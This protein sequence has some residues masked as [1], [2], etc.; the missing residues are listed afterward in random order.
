MVAKICSWCCFYNSQVFLC[1]KQQINKH[2]SSDVL[3]KES[4]NSEDPTDINKT[5]NHLWPQIIEYIKRS[6]HMVWFFSDLIN[7]CISCTKNE[8]LE[9]KISAVKLL[10]NSIKKNWQSKHLRIF[11][12]FHFLE[13]HPLLNV[14]KPTEK[15]QKKVGRTKPGKPSKSEKSKH[16]YRSDEVKHFVLRHLIL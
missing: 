5:S 7:L 6:Q 4:L 13:I 14:K 2:L 16:K 10:E 8:S 12:L 15:T 3:W 11:I 1:N 9:L